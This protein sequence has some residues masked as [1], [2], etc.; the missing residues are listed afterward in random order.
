MVEDNIRIRQ[1]QGFIL[2][3]IVKPEQHIFDDVD[4]CDLFVIRPDNS[5]GRSQT[6]GS[7]K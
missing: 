1:Y 2:V 3:L 4:T 7:G 6:M 5:L